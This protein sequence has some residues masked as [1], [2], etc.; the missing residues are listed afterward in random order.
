MKNKAALILIITVVVLV[1]LLV[2]FRTQITALF[3]G[4][5]TTTTPAETTATTT[6][7]TYTPPAGAGVTSP[8]AVSSSSLN[9]NLI[10]TLG[11]TGAEVSQLQTWLN[12][13]VD[14]I[15]GS[16]TQ[17]ALYQATGQTT[18]TL[19]QFTNLMQ[20]YAAGTQSIDPSG[21]SSQPLLQNSFGDGLINWFASL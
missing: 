16:A 6:A 4:K 21:D 9:M 14:G 17:N 2:V 19:N 1:L 8:L 13:G 7:T 12:T 5:A 15:F 3:S 11:S 18:I 20:A 10:L